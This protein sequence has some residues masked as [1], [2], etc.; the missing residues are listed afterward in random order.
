MGT[1]EY[2]YDTSSNLLTALQTG[3]MG[4]LDADRTYVYDTLDRL[5]T[6]RLTDTQDWNA[7]TE[8]TSWYQYDD[9]GNRISHQYRDAAPIAYEHDLANRMTQRAG[10]DQ[11]YDRAGN[12]T[13]GYSVN[14]ANTY[15]YRYDHHHRLTGVYDET[16]AER[17]A[18]FT[19]D[20]PA[21]D[22]A[23]AVDAATV[24]SV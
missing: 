16:G 24:L 23:F 9:L 13:L 20:V 18:G 11:G 4:R 15:L 10:M 7:A 12:L 17:L 6:A 19:L 3:N 5:L 2:T 21:A 14:G 1:F 8:K 22:A